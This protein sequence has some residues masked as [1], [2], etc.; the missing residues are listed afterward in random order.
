MALIYRRNP[1]LRHTSGALYAPL[2]P[3]PYEVSAPGEWCPGSSP[4]DGM[5]WIRGKNPNA[6]TAG[7][8]ES[9]RALEGET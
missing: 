5:G 2:L 9:S 6:L 8:Q 4:L 7:N 3:L 1:I